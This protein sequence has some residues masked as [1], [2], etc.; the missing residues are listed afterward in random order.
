MAVNIIG[1]ID[2][3]TENKNRYILTLVDYT[4]RYPEAIA[5]PRIETE[6][7]AEA[8]VEIFSRMGVPQE[9]LSDK[10]SQFTSELMREVGRLL[11]LRQMTTTPYHPMCNGL[12]E[13]FNRTLKKMLRKMCAERP[14]DWDRYLPAL[15]FSYR[16]VPQESLNFSPFELMFGRSVR[17]LWPF[18]KNYGQERTTKKRSKPLMN[19]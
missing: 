18:S 10:G 17:G 13:K 2:P 9:I 15:L 11:S 19:M 8:L 3:I 6:H 5:L 1:P 14:R 12:V 4:T 16:E 7:V